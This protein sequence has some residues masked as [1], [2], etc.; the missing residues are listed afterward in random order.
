MKKW[1]DELA[2]RKHMVRISDPEDARKTGVKLTAKG[3]K[4]R[5][6]IMTMVA[7]HGKAV[8]ASIGGPHGIRTEALAATGRKAAR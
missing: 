8:R 7:R 6:A 2:R 5:A 4:E 1:L 3:R